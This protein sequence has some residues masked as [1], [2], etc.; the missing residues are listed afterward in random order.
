MSH[1]LIGEALN[2]YTFCWL[3]GTS[4][5]YNYRNA[6]KNENGITSYDVETIE[7]YRQ[8]RITNDAIL[9]LIFPLSPILKGFQANGRAP[10]LQAGG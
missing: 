2:I 1:E 10:A 9:V 5:G 3:H 6:L 8:L 7:K 4:K